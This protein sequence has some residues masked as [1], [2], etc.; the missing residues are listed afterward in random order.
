MFQ[1]L[2]L[3]HDQYQKMKLALRSKD[4]ISTPDTSLNIAHSEWIANI[5]RFES[6]THV[7]LCL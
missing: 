6:V 4:D 2:A 3:V 1:Q 7:C 5:Y